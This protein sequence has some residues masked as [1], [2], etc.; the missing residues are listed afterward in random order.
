MGTNSFLWNVSY[1]SLSEPV[2]WT[3]RVKSPVIIGIKRK[4]SSW[5]LLRVSELSSSLY[6]EVFNVHVLVGTIFILFFVTQF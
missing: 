6:K 4:P 5:D 1:S 2:F 3:T